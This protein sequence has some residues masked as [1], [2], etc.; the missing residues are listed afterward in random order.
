[1]TKESLSTLRDM[2]MCA[3]RFVSHEK[4]IDDN[5]KLHKTNQDDVQNIIRFSRL[6]TLLDM[7]SI[8]KYHDNDY[9]EVPCKLLEHAISY[10]AGIQC[11]E[12]Y[13]IDMSQVYWDYYRLKE[14]L[15]QNMSIMQ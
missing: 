9:V 13:S 4:R 10:L 7:E 6:G 11:K 14:K 2:V 3:S 12:D 8:N 15:A 5:K 1:M